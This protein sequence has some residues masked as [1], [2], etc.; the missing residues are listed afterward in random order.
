[1]ALNASERIVFAQATLKCFGEDWAN[2]GRFLRFLNDVAGVALITNVKSE[3]LTWAPFIA[4]G[5]SIP[6][7]NLDLQR[8]YDGTTTT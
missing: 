1:M 3:A 7:W 6:A 4:S 2:T 8:T 5:L